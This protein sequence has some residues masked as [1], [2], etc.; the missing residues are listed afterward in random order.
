GIAYQE[1]ASTANVTY[2][3]SIDKTNNA[4]SAVDI[5]SKTGGTTTFSGAINASTTT[6]N[7]INLASNTGGT[8]TF[9]GGLVVSTTSGIGF[10]ATGSGATVNVCDENPCVPAATGALVNTL[11]S[12]TGT[13]LNVANTTIGANKLEFRSISSNGGSDNGIILN[14]TGTTAGLTVSGNGGSCTSAATCTGG[15]IQNKTGVDG[16]TTQGSGIFLNNTSGV[17]LDRMQLNNFDNFAIRGTAVIGFSLSNSNINGVNGN[18]GAFDEGSVSFDGLTGSAAINSCNISG[19]WE[20]NVRVLNAS[21][22][23]NRLNVTN[24]TIGLN[25]LNDGNNGIGLEATGASTILNATIS[26]G[27]F[28]GT[29]ADWINATTQTNSTMDID[30]LNNTFSNN[31]TNSGSAG[32]RVIVASNGNTTYN[33]SG[34][35]LRDSKGS[36]IFANAA[37][38]AAI[39]AGRIENNTIGVVAVPNSGSSEASGIALESNGG[40]DHTSL[41]NNNTI[42]QYNNHAIAMTLGTTLGNP[43]NINFTI[44]GNTATNP[45][46]VNND[47][48]AIHLNNGTAPGENFTSCVDVG[49]AGV[50]ANDVDQG[51]DGATAQLPNT[52]DIRL[53]QRQS[54]TVRL[55]G[56]SGANNND[57][58][59]QAYL[60]GRNITRVDPDGAAASNTVP[61]GGG[62]IGGAVCTQPPAAPETKITFGSDALVER[63]NSASAQ[64]T[65]TL[66]N[67]DS[68]TSRPFISS[69]QPQ[70]VAATTKSAGQA[71]VASAVVVESGLSYAPKAKPKPGGPPTGDGLPTQPVIVG[72]NLTWNVGTLPAGQSV[73]ITFQVTVDNPFTG[74]MPQVSNQGTVTA[75]G[76][77]NLLTDDPSV[78]G[79]NDPTVTLVTVPP[80]LFVRDARVAEPV[81][82]STSMLFTL[83][84]ST[85]A[86]TG[87][88]VVNLST[89]NG[90]ATGG[91]CVGGADYESV[92]GGTATFAVGEQIKTFPVTVCSDATV[93]GDETLFLNVNTAPGAVIVDG[94]GL[95]TITANVAG[96]TLISELRTSGP[97][98][99]GDDFVEIYNNT[100][101]PFTVPAGDYGLFKRGA[102]CDALPVLIG[103]IPAATVIPQRGHYL[104]V[105]STYSLANYGGIGAAA[106]NATLTTDIESD[107]NVGLFATVDPLQ[108]STANR[109]DAV[110]FG[111]S[112]S[113][114]CALLLEGTTLTPAEGSTSQYSFVREFKLFNNDVP[115]PTDGNDNA[116]DFTLVSTTP[117]TAVGQ[118]APTLGAPGPENLAGP[119]LKKYSQVGAQLIDPLVSQTVAPNRVRDTTPDIP[120][121][122]TLG[123]LASRRTFTN[124]TGA[125]ITRLRFRIYDITTFPSPVGT[126]DLRVRTS[127][128]ATVTVTGGGMLTALATTLETPP[129]Q[130]SSGGLNSSLAAGTVTL[131]TPLANGASIHLNFL[132]GVQQS[133]SFRVF[134]FVEAV[135]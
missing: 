40:G 85:P 113:G 31:H 80:D 87:G 96:T 57:A 4:A 74:G 71:P 1:N 15:A 8:V 20:D 102:S 94:Q 55:P 33:I 47:F 25:S 13:A 50:L 69:P 100:D 9:R 62:F 124:N 18:N 3:G 103:T 34:N 114:I 49:G 36:A 53:R 24:T 127:T 89:A 91:T 123:T 83:A 73:T 72:D 21:G 117:L 66:A 10:N 111:F 60:R 5:G 63:I 48:N 35:T 19:A 78:G 126:A 70:T 17:S 58:A 2:N 79:M 7:A 75:D 39:L 32:V 52:A 129:L 105:G 132:F 82:G 133:G 38:T 120:N 67:T 118:N 76:G 107:F 29:R 56:Y 84:L 12:T 98:G 125:P 27:T 64:E 110:G 90:S 16:S 97:G 77:I 14:N 95:G 43:T 121:N 6:A 37:N 86:P 131:G 134:V 81:A 115:T 59:V 65:A 26:G 106:G 128:N 28:T 41:V 112:T 92:T 119:N 116:A 42:R 104:F 30:V 22:T 54:T 68:V 23:L 44:T 109:L 101:T 130:P 46:T 108:V 99:A 122:S 11:T 45:G 93:E 61:T 51:A 88:I 135:P